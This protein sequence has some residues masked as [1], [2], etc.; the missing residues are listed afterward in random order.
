[1]AATKKTVGI[2]PKAPAATAGALLAPVLAG[3][4]AKLF[5]VEVDD[6]TVELVLTALFSAAGA[7]TGAYVAPPGAVKTK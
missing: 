2:S 1:M 6:A 4:V 5:G 7:L 3:L